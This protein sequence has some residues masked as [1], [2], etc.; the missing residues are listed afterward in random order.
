[1][2]L[3][4]LFGSCSFCSYPLF[5]K[6]NWPCR[7]SVSRFGLSYSFSGRFEWTVAIQSD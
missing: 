6:L 5:I 1:M 3:R 7:R 4:A 2:F